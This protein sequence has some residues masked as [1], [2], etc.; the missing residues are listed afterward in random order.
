M[1]TVPVSLCTT[2][3]SF[4]ALQTRFNDV[5]LLNMHKQEEINIEY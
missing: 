1:L 4:S 3:L 2:E 5:A